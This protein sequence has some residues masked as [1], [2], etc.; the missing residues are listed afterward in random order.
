MEEL[1][2]LQLM[3]PG[4]LWILLI[5]MLVGVVVAGIDA[6]IHGC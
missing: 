2:L 6:A 1:E 3:F 5:V 4:G